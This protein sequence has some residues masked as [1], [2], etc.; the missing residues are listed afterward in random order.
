MR[1][2]IFFLSLPFLLAFKFNPMSQTI[3]LNQNNKAAQ[4]LLE[5]DS[6][7]SMAIELTVVERQMDENGKEV[8]PKTKDL[9]IFPPQMVIPSKEKRTIRVSWVG[10][11][12]LSSEKAYRV[13]AEQL[14]LNVDEK[15]K[16]RSGI[17][18]LMKY[19]AAL[20]VAPV[21]A[22]PKIATTI[23]SVEKDGVTLIIENS[24]SGH[25]ILSNPT[26]IF[27][28]EKKMTFKAK[29]LA[30]LAGENVLA[31]SKRRFKVKSQAA[32]ALDSK[33]TLKLED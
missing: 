12:E 4:F 15:T 30:G 7:E 26:V 19:M 22:E 9:T 16:R 17:Q 21:G 32:V 18:M 31:H 33:V 8:L 23:E 11:A 28:K 20:Y 10:A 24:G 13:I 5:N 27:E 14:P 29:E 25:R 3:E 6:A 1:F 2:L